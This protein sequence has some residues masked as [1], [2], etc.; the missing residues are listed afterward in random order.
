MASQ[1]MDPA[2]ASSNA[3]LKGNEGGHSAA[4]GSVTKRLQQEL[5]TLMMSGDKGISAFPESENLFKWIGTI[6]GAQ[7]TV[8]SGLRFR[9][10]LEFP[11]SYPYQAPRVK[12]VTPCFHPN[13][14]EQGLICLDI[15]K[16]K[17]SAL[18]DVRSIL[19]SIQSLLSEPNN[20]S[21]LNTTAAEL[22][23]NQEAFKAHL[24]ATFQK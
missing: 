4:K 13:V 19:L 20:E 23:D 7:D 12:F 21:P 5:M 22:W 9:V 3:A 15:L 17:W 10:S 24:L 16:E 6:D 14:D 11:A 8:Y 1:N 2:A 18:Y